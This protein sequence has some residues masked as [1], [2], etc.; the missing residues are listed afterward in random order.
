MEWSLEFVDTKLEREFAAQQ[1]ERIGPT[2]RTFANLVSVIV[3]AFGVISLWVVE[4]RLSVPFQG[5]LLVAF[6]CPATFALLTAR[7]RIG[8]RHQ[9]LFAAALTCI[10][11]SMVVWA[12][13]SKLLQTAPGLIRDPWTGDD[14]PEC[15]CVD[16]PPLHSDSNTTSMRCFAESLNSS[17]PL[18]SNNTI[19]AGTSRLRME[20]KLP[21]SIK[22][23]VEQGARDTCFVVNAAGER[24]VAEIRIWPAGEYNKNVFENYAYLGFVVWS[25][26]G[27]ASASLF[28]MRCVHAAI[29]IV[30]PGFVL[31]LVCAVLD[32]LRVFF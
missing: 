20:T 19:K 24:Q 3:G 31:M 26:F 7:T 25:I 11:L 28:S 29:A 8:K 16:E 9:A 17:T 18:G 13:L 14:L 10:L 32:P 2:L 12:C 6:V 27:T 22:R 23:V 4:W 15:A 5:T 30:L 1:G 21:T